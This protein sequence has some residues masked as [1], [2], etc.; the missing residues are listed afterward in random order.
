VVHAAPAGEVA[1]LREVLWALVPIGVRR[2]RFTERFWRLSAAYARR[3]GAVPHGERYW[4]LLP[5]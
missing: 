2:A 1:A 3:L 5:E 4:L